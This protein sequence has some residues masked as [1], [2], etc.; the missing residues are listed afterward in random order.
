VRILNDGSDGEVFLLQRE[1]MVIGRTEG[2]LT[3]PDDEALAP[4][5]ASVR[6]DGQ[7]AFLRDLDSK[8]GTFLRTKELDLF[9]G[10][11]ILVGMTVL[12]FSREEDRP[13]WKVAVVPGGTKSSWHV[14]LELPLTIGSGK[15]DLQ[16]ADNFVSPKHAEVRKRGERDHLVDLDSLNGTYYR[17]PPGRNEVVDPGGMFRVGRQVFRFD[18]S[19]RR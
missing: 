19:R 1:P 18:P 12:R 6:T 14:A 10:I 4:S 5:H 8:R 2:L 16:L 7:Q 11:E 9:D 17:I 15:R 13:G 3:F